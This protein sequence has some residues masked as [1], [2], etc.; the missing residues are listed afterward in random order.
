MISRDKE[1]DPPPKTIEGYTD[2][3]YVS[4]QAATIADKM[5]AQYQLRLMNYTNA[6]K[7]EDKE[8]KED[9]E[10]PPAVVELGFKEID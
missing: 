2:A 4:E 1:Q 6:T 10:A 7:G 8:D 5:L 3:D 9:K